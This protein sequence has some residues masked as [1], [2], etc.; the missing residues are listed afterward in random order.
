MNVVSCNNIDFEIRMYCKPTSSLP[1]S[2]GPLS[3]KISSKAI[4][5]ANAEV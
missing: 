2:N 5:L 1:N 3:E 4:K